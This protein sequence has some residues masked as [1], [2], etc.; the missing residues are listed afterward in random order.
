[1]VTRVEVVSHH[2]EEATQPFRG[3]MYSHWNSALHLVLVDMQGECIVRLEF[4]QRRPGQL[5]LRERVSFSR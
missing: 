3:H 1:M 2:C 4:P 5:S